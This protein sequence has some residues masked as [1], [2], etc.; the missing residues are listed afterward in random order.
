MPARVKERTISHPGFG[1]DGVR[2][3]PSYTFNRRR[4][5]LHK[6]ARVQR[7]QEGIGDC[8]AYSFCTMYNLD[9]TTRR[10][11]GIVE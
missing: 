11:F 3:A 8:R 4:I 7:D 10:G 9:C 2:Q 5:V 1:G 6:V